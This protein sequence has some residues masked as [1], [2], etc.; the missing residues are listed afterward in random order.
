MEL[1]VGDAVLSNSFLWEVANVA[2]TFSSGSGGQVSDDHQK[3]Y[4]PK[5]EIKVQA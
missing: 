4:K 5:P 3:M 1:M 2:L